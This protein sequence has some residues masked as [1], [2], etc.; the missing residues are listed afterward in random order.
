MIATLPMRAL[1][2]LEYRLAL[3][4]ALPALHALRVSLRCG[5][6]PLHAE[7]LQRLP[8]CA[9]GDPEAGLLV[10]PLLGQWRADLAQLGRLPPGAPLA[11]VASRPLARLLPERRGWPGTPLCTVPGGL[12]RLC[13][14]LT[15]A[16]FVV[17]A[18][19]GFHA[20]PAM[21]LSA[22][23]GLAER[24]E[25]PDLADRLLAASRQYYCTPGLF[26]PL[27]TVALVCARKS[28]R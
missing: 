10:E 6:P 24:A 11:I 16:G 27:C 12:R 18:G 19:Y 23:C 15:T 28:V 21:A 5:V 14:A 4:A 22:L 2:P 20:A 9:A 3:D 13:D 8:H 17:E 26:A 25:R 1:A 7:A